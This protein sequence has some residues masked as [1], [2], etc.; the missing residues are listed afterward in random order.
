MS[1]FIPYQVDHSVQNAAKTLGFSK[2]RISFKFGFASPQALQEGKTG[3]QCRG[4]E[5]ELIFVWSLK[6]GKRQLY[7][8]GKDVHFSESG[9]NGWTT[10]RM[11]QHAFTMRD[12][13]GNYRVHFVSQPKDP[14]MPDIKPFDMRVAG[15]SY[16]TFN[17]IY[18]LGTPAMRVREN[19]RDQTSGGRYGRESPVTPEERQQIAAAKAASLRDFERRRQAERPP[20]QQQQ[21]QQPQMQREEENLLNFDDDPTPAPPQQQPPAQIAGAGYAGSQPFMSNIS[22][23]SAIDSQNS[24]QYGSGGGYGQPPPAAPGQYGTPGYAYG[25]APPAQYGQQQQPQSSYDQGFTAAPP[26]LQSTTSS[27]FGQDQASTTSSSGALTPYQAPAGQPAPSPYAYQVQQT[28][29]PTYQTSSGSFGASDFQQQLGSPSAQSY[30]SYGSAPSFA[31]PPRPPVPAPAPTGYPPQ[32][33]SYGYPPQ[34]PASGGGYGAPPPAYGAPA[35]A[36]YPNQQ[37]QQQ[38]QPFGY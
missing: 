2:K 13:T 31:Q 10:D 25:Q 16:F 18:E 37:Q 30:A 20:P 6:T 26:M 8:D 3:A 4:S 29:P 36:A 9:Q 22:M 14:N 15:A 24:S 32:Q 17:K 23:D 38:Q 11:W 34:A 5:H 33:P 35:P 19:R 28:A 7:L 27:S 21:Q 1:T 12:V